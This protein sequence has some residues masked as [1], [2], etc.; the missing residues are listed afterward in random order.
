M[1]V[2]MNAVMMVRTSNKMIKREK[3]RATATTG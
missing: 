3:T 1:M 2:V